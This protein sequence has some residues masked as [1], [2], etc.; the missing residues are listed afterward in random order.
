[1][2][3]RPGDPEGG[4]ADGSG[5]IGKAMLPLIEEHR[6]QIAALCRQF[7]VR[8]LAVF[9]SAAR[10]KDF[11]PQRSDVDFEVAFDAPNGARLDDFLALRDALAAA[12]GRPV[13]LVMA[14]SVR[15][16]Y[17]RDAIRRSAETI[18]GA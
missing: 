11:D 2:G 17:L 9:G 1:M 12:V 14:G 13:D 16:P 18:Y 7:G 10:E 8:R 15:N 5:M 3:G 4:C 6:S